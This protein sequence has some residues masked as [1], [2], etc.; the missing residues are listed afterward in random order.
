MTDA[1]TG[2]QPSSAPAVGGQVEKIRADVAI[3]GG[4]I[5][6]SSAAL[7]LRRAGLSVVLMER[8]LCGAAAS[9]VNYGG[10]R[11]QGRAMSQLPLAMRARRIWSAL[12]AYIG[13]DG[14]Y[15][16]S[17]HLK[18]ARSE[19]DMARLETYAE[20]ARDHGLHL[21]LSS[22]AAFRQ[23]H[24]WVG[25]QALGASYCA[26]DG[27]ANPRLVS[28][29][30]ARA[31]RAAGAQV[32]EHCTVS[33]VAH[34]GGR[35]IVGDGRSLEVS[36]EWLLN[37]AGA[38]ALDISRRFGDS[39][40]LTA[41]HPGMAVTEAVPRFMD[42]NVGVEGGGIYGRQTARG[43]CVMGGSRG[44]S[45]GPLYA[46]PTAKAIAELCQRMAEL[47]PALA[48][49]HVIRFWSGVEG[50]LP[51]HQPI[52]GASPN[53]P[54]LIHAFG[55]CGAG[56]QTGPA[57]GELLAELVQRGHCGIDLAPFALSRFSELPSL[58]PS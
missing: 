17:G 11:T 38:W 52:I 24:P 32:F 8:G 42:V 9:G 58:V 7:F 22:G 41:I 4:G 44:A 47:F 2:A 12:P 14:E 27:H 15:V 21:Q 1:T 55:F 13:I 48:H 54:N 43:N 46:A 5:V 6:G 28:P 25:K 30:F 35:F 10:V 34:T 20:V 31:A 29:A 57:V 53:T 16:V 37:C 19:E 50:S 18:I 49:A 36:S 51:D 45:T 39:A 26:E 40:P 33:E 56:F 23:A 3:V